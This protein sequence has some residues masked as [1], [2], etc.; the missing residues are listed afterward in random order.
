MSAQ[1]KAR[2]ETPTQE[3]RLLYAIF[4]KSPGD[5]RGRCVVQSVKDYAYGTDTLV[6]NGVPISFKK[7]PDTKPPRPRNKSKDSEEEDMSW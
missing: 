5:Y 3:E 2:H 7:M 1:K 6:V 4:G